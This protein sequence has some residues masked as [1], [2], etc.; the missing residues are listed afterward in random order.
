MR[1]VPLVTLQKGASKNSAGIQRAI[2]RPK[3][4]QL[5]VQLFHR[6]NGLA[7]LDAMV[8]VV[9]GPDYAHRASCM[10]VEDLLRPDLGARQCRGRKLMLRPKSVMT[11]VWLVMIRRFAF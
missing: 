8:P 6:C 11:G 10:P 5:R 1:S 4:S 3:C 9:P 2:Q 7:R